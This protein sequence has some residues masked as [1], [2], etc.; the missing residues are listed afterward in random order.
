MLRS[1]DGE[2]VEDS[3]RSRGKQRP[4]RALKTILFDLR[5]PSESNPRRCRTLILLGD[6]GVATIPR[7]FPGKEG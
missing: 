6:V 4:E 3:I 5:T 1:C 7:H 2:T